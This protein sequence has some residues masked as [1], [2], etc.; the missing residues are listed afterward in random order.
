MTAMRASALAFLGLG[1]VWAASIAACG[2]DD[3][4]AGAGQQAAAA[5]S[6]GAAGSGAAGAGG[7]PFECPP[8]K[9]EASAGV[10]VD[11]PAGEKMVH[12]F[13]EETIEAGGEVTSLCR[14]WTLGNETETWVHAVQFRQNE[15]SHHANFVFVPDTEYAG[16]DGFWSCPDRGYDFYQATSKGGLLYPQSTQATVELQAFPDGAALRLPPHT[17]IVSDVH[18][19]NAT[20]EA[21]TGHATLTLYTVPK[22][23]VKTKLSPFHI[24][25]VDL[26]VPPHGDA[27]YST[28]CEIAAPVSAA[29]GVPWA[30]KLYYTLPHTHQYGKRVFLEILGGPND[31]TKIF[32]TAAYDGAAHGR[33]YDPPIDLTGAKG[34]R[35]GCEFR[36]PTDGELQWGFA[37]GE[38]CEIFGFV[39]DAPF[40]W[41]TAGMSQPAGKDGSVELFESGCDAGIQ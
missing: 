16:D 32:E 36:N 12:A 33:A 13:A 15:V 34:F 25:Y 24:E 31:G 41:A 22:E 35:Y 28:S 17:R 19:V 2:G 30:P 39:N 20:K 21:V 1:W 29:T 3:A 4:A 14:S 6:A 7:A 11:E 8:G 27:R 37:A 9:I 5:G 40:F 26:H 18:L 38:M 10:C 23:Q